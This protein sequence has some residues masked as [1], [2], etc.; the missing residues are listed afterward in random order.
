[1]GTGMLKSTRGLPVQIPNNVKVQRMLLTE[2]WD[3]C[4][5]WL[6]MAS[7]MDA[8]QTR[9]FLTGQNYHGEHSLECSFVTE[10]EFKENCLVITQMK[11]LGNS[12]LMMNPLLLGSPSRPTVPSSFSQ[13]HPWS[14]SPFCQDSLSSRQSQ[15]DRGHNL[16]VRCCWSQSCSPSH[17][18]N[19]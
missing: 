18:Q 12:S 14:H 3:S 17:S 13:S 2:K 8:L 16:V 11:V 9:G 10:D 7:E 15:G 5:I 19:Q 6:Q 4:T 1:M